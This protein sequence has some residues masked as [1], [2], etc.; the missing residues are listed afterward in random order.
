VGRTPDQPPLRW[1]IAGYGEVVVSRALPALAALGQPVAGIWG[2]NPERAADVARRFDA[3][4]G[5]SCFDDLLEAVDLVYIATPVVDHVPLA[6]QALRAGRPVLVEKPLAG[7]LAGGQRLLTAGPGGSLAGAVA[8]YR[9]LA[10]TWLAVSDLA[11]DR[12]P[13]RIAIGFRKVFSPEKED[14]KYWRTR[15]E[16]SGGGVLA[17]AGCH[18]ID[19][20]FSLLGPP[21]TGR[22][23]LAGRY[24]SGAERVARLELSWTDGSRA[25]LSC[26]WAASGPER[27]SVRITGR[28]LDLR[29]PD[30][31]AGIVTVLADRTRSQLRLPPEG[32]VLLPTLRDFLASLATGRK[33]ACTLADG[34]AVDDVIRSA[35]CGGFRGVAPPGQQR[36]QAVVAA[37]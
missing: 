21:A 17:D 18:R 32:N 22:A 7:G 33:P 29:L 19:L 35:Y 34:V 10:P 8:Y 16:I 4:R 13:V 25:R 20:L 26:E 36:S 6:D 23:T 11:R 1:G 24:P 31:D 5:F 30:L 15:S 3:G 37:R 9:R 14:P 2:R 28:G 27:D 12:G